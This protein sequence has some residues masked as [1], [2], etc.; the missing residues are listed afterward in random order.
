MLDDR[1]VEVAVGK[2]I[3]REGDQTLLAEPAGEFGQAGRVPQIP[4]GG[5]GQ[6]EPDPHWFGGSVASLHGQRMAFEVFGQVRAR[7]APA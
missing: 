5:G 1:L 6:P 7:S 3:E 4:G 2:P